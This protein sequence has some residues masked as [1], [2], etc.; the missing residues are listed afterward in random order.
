MARIKRWH[1]PL[2]VCAAIGLASLLRASPFVPALLVV[3][4]ALIVP[5]TIEALQ[6]RDVVEQSWTAPNSASAYGSSQWST[7]FT[8]LRNQVRDTAGSVVLAPDGD[9]LFMWQ[10]TGAQPF[11]LWLSG[12]TKLGFEPANL[13]SWSYL[14]RVQLQD[15]AFRSGLAGLCGLAKR[16]GA[17]SI[18]LRHRG[19]LLGTHDRRPASRW[20]VDPR[21]RNQASIRRKV[22]AH[23]TYRDLNSTEALALTRGAEIPIGWS[24]AGVR[25]LDVTLLRASRPDSLVLR[26]PDGATLT[27]RHGRRSTLQF[28]VNGIPAGTRLVAQ[29]SVGLVRVI[30]FEPSPIA[31]PAGPGVVNLLAAKVCPS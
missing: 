4:V 12:S 8:Q 23:T 21:D 30:G 19:S 28:Q 24:S 29:H 9:A 20:R 5:S 6:T 17:P 27:P 2:V 14:A 15:R 10:N 25:Q 3:A 11:S 22:Q 7:A 18:L 1:I 13:T 31:L 16:V 26:M